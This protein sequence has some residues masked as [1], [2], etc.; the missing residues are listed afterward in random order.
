MQHYVQEVMLVSF[1]PGVN[2]QAFTSAYKAQDCG[3]RNPELLPRNGRIRVNEILWSATIAFTAY[4]QQ[5]I[6]WQSCVTLRHW[7]QLPPSCCQVKKSRIENKNLTAVYFL[8]KFLALLH[9]FKDGVKVLLHSKS[10]NLELVLRHSCSQTQAEIEGKYILPTYSRER[11]KERNCLC[12]SYASNGILLCQ[13]R[14]CYERH[15]NK[16]LDSKISQEIQF[17]KKTDSQY[18]ITYRVN[19][20]MPLTLKIDMYMF[21]GRVTT[22][23]SVLQTMQQ[24]L[25]DHKSKWS[26]T[27]TNGVL[28]KFATDTMRTGRLGVNDVLQALPNVRYKIL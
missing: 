16:E 17:R 25:L 18:Y 11:E 28:K 26:Q 12:R 6:I 19:P 23:F 14:R 9:S 2:R 22:L 8:H 20:V 15:H 5:N 27:L 13:V 3:K 1:L 4:A 24:A 7:K 21:S 10:L